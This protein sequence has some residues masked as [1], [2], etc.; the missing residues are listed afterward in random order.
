MACR[1]LIKPF[2][3]WTASVFGNIVDFDLNDAALLPDDIADMME[4]GEDV[5][6]AKDK[7]F[8][9]AKEAAAAM[10]NNKKLL[11]KLRKVH[12]STVFFPKSSSRWE[13]LSAIMIALHN[14]AF[15]DQDSDK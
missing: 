7:V 14:N 11:S 5:V 1:G 9:S 12:E 10:K 4:N 13:K 8:N 6:K 15:S 2:F 3:E